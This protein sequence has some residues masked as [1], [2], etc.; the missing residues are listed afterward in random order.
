MGQLLQ[1]GVDPVSAGSAGE[2][3]MLM[4]HAAAVGRPF[5][6]ALLDHQMPDCDGAELGRIIMSDDTLECTRLI[7]LTSS[8]Q[9]GEGQLYADLGFAGYLLKPVSQRDLTDCLMLALGSEADTWRTRNLPMM[10]R[11]ALRAQRPR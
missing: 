4:R 5:D 6:A 1:C 2:A 10:T 3:L 9:R 7:L 8:G 11:H